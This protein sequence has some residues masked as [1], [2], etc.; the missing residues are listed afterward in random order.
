MYFDKLEG[1]TI[2]SIELNDDGYLLY[3]TT[4]KSI[5]T[6]EAV[7]DCCA[8]AYI[9]PLDENDVKA[10]IGNTV[11]KTTGSPINILLENDCNQVDVQ[12]YSIKTMFSDLDIELRTEHNGY[13]VGWITLRSEE[14][15]SS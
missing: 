2:R 3:I 5:Y 6:F 12:F 8:H 11:I 7:G 13:Y 4:G 9:L 14:P 15:V 1:Q 10:I